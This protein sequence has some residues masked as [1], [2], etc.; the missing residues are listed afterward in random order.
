[1]CTLWNLQ[2]PILLYY[3][4][5]VLELICTT[6]ARYIFTEFNSTTVYWCPRA[7]HWVPAGSVVL[8]RRMLL[9]SDYSK[10]LEK[11]CR[12]LWWCLMFREHHGV[13]TH[14]EERLT[15]RAEHVKL[16][17]MLVKNDR[18]K[19]AECD[20][21]IQ[22]A[23]SVCSGSEHTAWLTSVWRRMCCNSPGGPISPWGYTA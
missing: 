15:E 18:N 17:C 20:G 9:Y 6:N 11:F 4:H 2:F 1:M 8:M 23:F 5:N 7:R 19:A 12:Y 10:L 3:P 22:Y 13:N 14:F 16:S 21:V